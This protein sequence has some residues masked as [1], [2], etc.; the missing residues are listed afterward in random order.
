MADEMAEAALETGS[1]PFQA[2]GRLIQELGLRLVASPEVALVE[3]VKNAYDADSPVCRVSMEDAG[4]TLLVSDKGHGMSFSDFRDKW[5][6]IATS[7]KVDRMTSPLYGRKM[8]GAKGI[9]RFAVRSLGD[10]LSLES[11]AFDE[12]RGYKTRLVAE[13]DWNRLDDSRS[14]SD[15]KVRYKLFKVPDNTLTGT[16]LRVGEMK[17]ENDFAKSKDLRTQ[18]LSMVSP[19]TGLDRGRFELSRKRGKQDPGFQVS[20]PGDVESTEQGIDLAAQVL[21][22]S[23]AQL[24]IDLHEQIL[25]F[26][27]LFFDSRK[28]VELKLKVS[29]T[30]AGGFHADIRFFPR[31]K[32][33][34]SGKGI[35]GFK[36]WAWVREN[37]GVAVIDHGFRI[38]PFG[39]PD[40]D[41]LNLDSDKAHNERDWRTEIAKER[42]GMSPLVKADPG[43]NPVLNSPYNYQLVGA[44]FLESQPLS[45]HQEAKGLVPSMDREGFLKNAAFEQLQEFVRAGI[46][47]LANEDKKKLREIEAKEA[48][49]AAQEARE[50]I[51]RAIEEIESSPT[52]TKGDKAR[53]VKQYT[54]I[55]D[56]VDAQEEYAAQ[57]RKGLLNMSLLGIVAGFMTHESKAIVHELEKSVTDLRMYAKK[58]PELGR[59]A[60]EVNERITVFK[61]Y[62]DYSRLF[63]AKAKTLEDQPMV[64]QAQVRV[65]IN[66][67][68]H[69]TEARDIEVQ[70]EVAG[71]VTTPPLPVT[72]Y[73]GVLLNLFTNAIKAVVSVRD[74]IDKPKVTFRGWNER[75]KH[76]IEVLDNGAGIPY[77]LRKR[78]WDPLYTT[79]S[80]VENPLGS[81]MG[82]GLT[83][84]KQMVTE[85]NGRIE[86]IDDIP[87]GYSTCF[88]V[89][90]PL[91]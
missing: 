64:A 63:I 56:R 86:I 61:G 18:V 60:D 68:L 74:S 31:R 46:E 87:A 32:G 19:I 37:C 11:I 77:D 8:T 16:T 84:V 54:R 30:I 79:T 78:I 45:S 7:S 81:G 28:P 66:R 6:R 67:F 85:L 39:Y 69:F 72:A 27:V 43:E 9:G 10:H 5:M 2:E 13:F 59:A 48:E 53:I 24:T 41:W 22:N 20:L 34:F 83:L 35:D 51:K 58:F 49:T 42:F 12:E 57:A 88:R 38:K 71:D 70:N 1:I 89:T 23:W 17:G 52:L 3:L 4:K 33:V 62:L 29:S 91:K 47:F 15:E 40:D 55:S 73:S 65:V 90:L 75:G 76:I 44:V 50:E 82:L 36:A 21:G 14:I 80:D 26:K 25:G